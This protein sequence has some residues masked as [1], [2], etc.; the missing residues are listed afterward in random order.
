M[1]YNYHTHTFR[2]MHAA[3]MDE[4][5]VLCAIEA[6][7]EEI[8]FSDHCPWPYKNYVSG[9]RMKETQLEDYVNS[10]KSLK[11]KYKDKI[12]IKLGLECE[13]FREYIPWL[14][15]M[16]KKYG[17]DYIILGHHYSPNEIDGIYNGY[18]SCAEDV[19][20]YK[21]DVL[22]A[23]DTGMFSYIAHPDLFM[24]GYSSFDKT[25]KK[26]S[27]EI[28]EKSIETGIPIEYN[29]MGILHARNNGA[30]G[31]PCRKFWELAGQMG[32]VAVIG[33][34]AHNPKTFLDYSLY[35]DAENVLKECGVKVLDK[36][37]LLK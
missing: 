5:Y 34:D 31:Y 24:L 26:A 16:L 25:A 6:G 22:E 19:I 15:R 21:N 37:K 23:V 35:S 33:V 18:P 32:A 3:G 30:E 8:G 12:S 9:M 11:E 29:L 1:K 2:C 17:F 27:K 4:E 10:V 20:S 28:I 14:K 36:I 13:Y 7:F